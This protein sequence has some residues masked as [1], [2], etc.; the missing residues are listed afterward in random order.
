MHVKFSDGYTYG[1]C[2]ITGML[3]MIEHHRQRRL[4]RYLLVLITCRS[5]DID[6]SEGLNKRCCH[7]YR[8]SNLLHHATAAHQMYITGSVV[9][10]TRSSRSAFFPTPPLIFT[11][12]GVKSVTFGHDF[13]LR[14]T[15]LDFEPLSFRNGVRYLKSNFNYD[16]LTPDLPQTLKVNGSSFD[17]KLKV[18]A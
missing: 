2:L 11:G 13:R 9:G 6:M 1:L 5:P 15:T 4:P 12:R 16:H 7:F 17:S 18:T 10:S 8:T 14:S 3:T